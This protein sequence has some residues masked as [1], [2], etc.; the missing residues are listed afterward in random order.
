MKKILFV[1]LFTMLAVS[2]GTT[3]PSFESSL[4]SVV[5]SQG[6]SSLISDTNPTSSSVSHSSYTTSMNSSA[7]SISSSTSF[8]SSISS[9]GGLS[10]EETSYGNQLLALAKEKLLSK[11]Y[12]PLEFNSSALRS[13][14]I[15]QTDQISFSSP[16]LDIDS[17]YDPENV[18]Y[19]EDFQYESNNSVQYSLFVINFFKNNAEMFKNYLENLILLVDAFGVYQKL[20]EQNIYFKLVS[21]DI[22][23]LESLHFYVLNFD[24]KSFAYYRLYSDLGRSA[25]E[26]SIS[27]SVISPSSETLT[28]TTTFQNIDDSIIRVMVMSE[29]IY[30]GLESF[31]KFV[32]PEMYELKIIDDSN[33]E[34]NVLGMNST[35]KSNYQNEIISIERD[36]LEV[37]K[38]VVSPTHIFSTSI[39]NRTDLIGRFNIEYLPDRN[40]AKNFFRM[41]FNQ[42]GVHSIYTSLKLFETL[43]YVAY[44]EPSPGDFFQNLIA[45]SITTD[46]TNIDLTTTD[47]NLYLNKGRQPN[48]YS[49]QFGSV[50]FSSIEDMFEVLRPVKTTYDLENIYLNRAA[51]VEDIQETLIFDVNF[52]S[53][54]VNQWLSYLDTNYFNINN[55]ALQ[56]FEPSANNDFIRPFITGSATILKTTFEGMSLDEIKSLI[57]AVDDQDGPIEVTEHNISILYENDEP[58][59]ILYSISDRA[60]NLSQFVITIL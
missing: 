17:F 45:T 19:P 26:L 30:S 4:N 5:S 56:I 29:F 25:L 24:E 11:N 14:P 51:L 33:Y 3:L 59:S 47:N 23:T 36:S 28:T 1:P 55:P 32:N 53:M 10:S 2:C 60:N 37:T 13:N 21:D 46:E 49:M 27:R 42:S 6:E 16:D 12:F 8:S 38:T 15:N 31:G 35:L 57:T 54:D 44:R 34:I 7:L 50:Y 48:T 39:S 20:E 9:S 58:K 18:L 43:N 22:E 40:D 41:N 52:F